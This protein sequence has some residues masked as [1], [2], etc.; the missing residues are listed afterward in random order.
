MDGSRAILDY[1]RVA[2]TNSPRMPG[3]KARKV[4]TAL[5]ALLL[6]SPAAAQECQTCSMADACV[7]EFTRAR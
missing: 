6:S 4:R 7:R 1:E 2:A 3:G 5:V